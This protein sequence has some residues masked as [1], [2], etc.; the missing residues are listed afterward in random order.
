M[1][2]REE[3]ME[4]IPHRDP[5]LLIDEIH[6]MVP[7]ESAVAVKHV[8]GNEDFFRGH[9]PQYKVMPGVLIVEA[10]AQA[11]AAAILSLPEYKGK[12]GLFGGIDECRFKGQV[13]PGDEL[14]LH[15]QIVRRKG[16]IGVGE[17]EAFVGGKRVA[18][19]KLTFAVVDPT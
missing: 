11:G 12:I 15:V 5:M 1:L 9:F 18:K 14:E 16:P 3:I 13:V 10:M 2:N 19:A 4:I 17:G 6:E 7:G 8:T